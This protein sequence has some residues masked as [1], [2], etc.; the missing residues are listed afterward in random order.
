MRYSLDI[1]LIGTQNYLDSV[2]DE[3]PQADDEVVD[4]ALYEEPTVGENMDSDLQLSGM[5]RFLEDTD[6]ETAKDAILNLAGSFEDALVGS[7]MALHT[8]YHDESPPKSCQET[9]V[10]EVVEDEEV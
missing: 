8:C 2:K 5:I 7:R 9:V 10:W 6:R 4:T 1:S 3:V